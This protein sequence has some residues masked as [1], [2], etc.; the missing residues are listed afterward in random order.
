MPYE[1]TDNT[2]GAEG[3]RAHLQHKDFA[4]A[5]LA[6]EQQLA[7]HPTMAE[8]WALKGL[9]LQGLGDWAQAASSF[10]RGLECD[11]GNARLLLFQGNLHTRFGRGPQAV[12]SY[13]AALARDPSLTDAYRGL[14]NFHTIPVDGPEVAKLLSMA[15]NEGRTDSS[16]AHALFLLGQIFVNAGIDHPG[17]AFFRQA[18]NLVAK[19]IE[20]DK[21]EY[22]ISAKRAAMTAAF[23]RRH[24]RCDP[25]SPAFPA[26]IVA[27][28]PR[29]GKSLVENLLASHPEVS[30]GGELALVRKFVGSLNERE[31]LE[32]LAAR[33]ARDTV[34]PLGQ[35]CPPLARGVRYLIDTSPANLN[36]LG[37]L[38]LL[39]PETPIIFCRRNPLDLGLALYFKYFSSGHR[40]SYQLATAGRAIAITDKLIEQW[41]KA[42]PNPMFEV[43]YEELVQDPRGTQRALFAGLGL[44]EP[45]TLSEDATAGVEWRLFPSRSIDIVGTISPALVGFAD[46]FRRQLEPLLKAYAEE[47]AR[48]GFEARGARSGRSG[49]NQR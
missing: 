3:I 21:R 38:A 12:A 14:L 13:T 28:L 18:N 24:A 34:S 48:E 2:S 22:Q 33:L 43:R 39:H 11:P 44:P 9:A 25:A 8:L 46:R 15:F 5:L 49:R 36:R 26:V 4:A 41:H 32:A 10:Q 42:L 35:Q 29:S 19:G 31:D 20:R 7:R 27:G 17:F 1:H 16:R 23:F 30:P 47:A 45:A 6:C 40:Y 37:F